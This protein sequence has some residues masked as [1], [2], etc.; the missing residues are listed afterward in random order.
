MKS[1]FLSPGEKKDVA[2]AA[3]DILKLQHPDCVVHVTVA[4]ETD[5]RGV[6]VYDYTLKPM[7][8]APKES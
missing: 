6:P 1:R 8:P 5:D 3:I 7:P 4:D 2:R